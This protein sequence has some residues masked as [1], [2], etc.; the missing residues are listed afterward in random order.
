[1]LHVDGSGG[2]DKEKMLSGFGLLLNR[3]GGE[4]R[5]SRAG[6]LGCTPGN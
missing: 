4:R 2:L 6:P 3:A 1:V 5:K